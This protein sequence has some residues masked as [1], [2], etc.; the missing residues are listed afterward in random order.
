MLDNEEPVF[1]QAEAE[2]AQSLSKGFS[3]PLKRL[4]MTI[5]NTRKAFSV[6]L[7]LCGEQHPLLQLAPAVRGRDVRL[8]EIRHALISIKLVFD[9]RET[10]ALIFIDFVVC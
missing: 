10:V 3:S 2:P 1:L 6:T 8:Q 7:G 5:H 9:T 4:G